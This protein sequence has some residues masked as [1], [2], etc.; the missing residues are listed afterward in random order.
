MDKATEST[1]RTVL[2]VLQEICSVSG[3]KVNY[4]KSDVL[5]SRITP[6]TKEHPSDVNGMSHTEDIGRYL[7]FPICKKRR[8]SSFSFI[9]DK[10][11]NKLSRWKANLLSFGGRSTQI[12]SVL[13]SIALYYMHGTHLTKKTCNEI[14]KITRDFLWGSPENHRKV[15]MVSWDVVTSAKEEGGL[16]IKDMNYLN[17]AKMVKLGWR[18]MTERKG[19]WREILK[20]K[21]LRNGYFS[22][23]VISLWKNCSPLWSAMLSCAPNLEKGIRW[24]IK[25]RSEVSFSSDN[26]TGMGP[27]NT[28]IYGPW[29][30]QEEEKKVKNT[31]TDQGDWDFSQVESPLPADIQLQIKA[32]P[33]QKVSPCNDTVCW[34]HS[35]DG[36]FSLM[37]AYNLVKG[38]VLIPN[39]EWTSIWK[40]LPTPTFY[41]D[42][43]PRKLLLD[44][45]SGLEECRWIPAA[46]GVV[47]GRNHSPLVKGL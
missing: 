33:I 14:N 22:M 45:R 32:I 25:T 19:L 12:K 1:C 11:R 7:G 37:L 9:V 41:G 3:Q 20:A 40:T 10:V 44:M 38:Q 8:V 16:V 5:F 36:S 6:I 30:K 23:K 21:Y 29:T 43:S 31:L 47:S 24:I 17:E 26:W 18:F 13:N 27:L 34:N 4:R 42:V 15:H 2:K 28:I 35:P 46:L 39:F